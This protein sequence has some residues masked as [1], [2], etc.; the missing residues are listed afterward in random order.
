MC[1]HQ[2]HLFC[3]TINTVL[4]L[5][6][7][8]TSLSS[9]DTLCCTFYC[10]LLSLS[11]TIFLADGWL[12]I[13]KNNKTKQREKRST[14]HLHGK[15]PLRFYCTMLENIINCVLT[16]LLLLFIWFLVCRTVNQ[17]KICFSLELHNETFVHMKIGREYLVRRKT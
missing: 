9:L 14:V 12:L 6:K 1:A 5:I 11:I 15:P 4:Q 13:I 8:V 2:Y 17:I 7:T 3:Y 16:F 10:H